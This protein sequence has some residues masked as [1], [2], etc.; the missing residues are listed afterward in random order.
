MKILKQL[1]FTIA[2]L[3]CFSIAAS[4]QK[5]DDKDKKPKKDP[6]VVVVKDREKPKEEKPKK[7]DNV[8]KPEMEFYMSENR[9]EVSLI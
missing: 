6:P 3:F 9:I 1:L 7:D 5:Q 4:A 8:K 2:V